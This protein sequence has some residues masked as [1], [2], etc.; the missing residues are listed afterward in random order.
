MENVIGN[1]LVDENSLIT[2]TTKQGN[3][4]QFSARELTATGRGTLGRIGVKLSKDDYVVDCEIENIKQSYFGNIAT[5]AKK[6]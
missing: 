5:K 6:V 4:L 1:I 2:L 3:K